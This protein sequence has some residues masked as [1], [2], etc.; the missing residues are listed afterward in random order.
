MSKLSEPIFISTDWAVAVS[1]ASAQS[2][3]SFTDRA[4]SFI[5]VVAFLEELQKRRGVG[6]AQSNIDAS[7]TGGLKASATVGRLALHPCLELLTGLFAREV[8]PLRGASL[9]IADGQY[10]HGRQLFFQWVEQMDANQVVFL[11]VMRRACS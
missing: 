5:A 11:P 6:V 4:K 10:A 3:K 1:D 8:D 7:R 2:K 9:R